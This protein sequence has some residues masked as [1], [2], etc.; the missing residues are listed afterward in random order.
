MTLGSWDADVKGDFKDFNEVCGSR[1]TAGTSL[2]CNVY[3]II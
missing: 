1:G 2:N 3:D